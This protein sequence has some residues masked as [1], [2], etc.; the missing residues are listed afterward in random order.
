MMGATFHRTPQMSSLGGWIWSPSVV[1]AHRPCRSYCSVKSGIVSFQR[2]SF[3]LSHWA[4]PSP[5]ASQE[6]WVAF[7]KGAAVFPSGSIEL[8]KDGC[9]S[10]GRTEAEKLQ[11]RRCLLAFFLLWFCAGSVTSLQLGRI[12]LQ[13]ASLNLE[14]VWG[15]SERNSHSSSW[16][17]RHM[18]LIIMPIRQRLKMKTGSRKV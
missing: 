9:P 14:K 16:K 8:A 2:T 15:Q 7:P 6:G 4:K 12:S 3:S 18:Q 11:F 17:D 10:W 1:G 13:R 5:A